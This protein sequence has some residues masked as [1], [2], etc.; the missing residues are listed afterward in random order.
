MQSLIRS[1][2]VLA[3][4]CC[5][6]LAEASPAAEA[7]PNQK[8][9]CGKKHKAQAVEQAGAMQASPCHKGKTHCPRKLFQEAKVTV[10]NTE[11]GVV[12]VLTADDPK[13][14][15]KLQAFWAQQQ[16]QDK[17]ACARSAA[18]CPAGKPQKPKAACGGGG[19]GRQ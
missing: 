4:V 8:G 19:C 15:E 13:V 5:L 10:S 16:V 1:A 12:V 17:Q 3:A 2:A 18:T 14:V 9:C 7:E 11:T 6:F